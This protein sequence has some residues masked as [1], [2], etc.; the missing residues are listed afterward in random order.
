MRTSTGASYYYTADAIGS[1]IL[2]TDST[3]AAATTYTYDSWGQT[4]GT[5]A[6]AANNPWQYAG[7]YKDTATGYTKFGARYYNPARGR[8]TQVDPS[9]QETNRYAYVSCNP[10]N[11][12]DPSGLDVGFGDMLFGGIVGG[13][14]GVGFGAIVTVAAGPVVGALVG[15]CVAGAITTGATNASAGLTSSGAEIGLGCATGATLGIAS[16]L[17]QS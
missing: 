15:G 3:Q 16:L 2:L 4:T 9:S 11:A 6:Q 5:G 14:I 7:G 12:T 17:G 8:F 13:L 10:I 1:T